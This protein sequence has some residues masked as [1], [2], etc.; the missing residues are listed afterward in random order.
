MD[1]NLNTRINKKTA[2][3]FDSR[4]KL[5]GQGISAVGHGPEFDYETDDDIYQA[6]SDHWYRSSVLMHNICVDERIKYF[7][8]L[9][10]CQ[11]LP[12][13]KKLDPE[14]IKIA[15]DP[16]AKHKSMVIAGYPFLKEKA[17]AFSEQGVD[18]YDLT[19]VFAGHPEPLYID[20]LCHFGDKGSVVMAEKIAEVILENI[21]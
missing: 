21:F 15:V 19:G 4:T 11:Y 5:A 16:K 9:Q 7:H 8:F 10:P 20:T 14:E 13:T 17:Q 6:L 12:D 1:R 3:L 18:F 2:E